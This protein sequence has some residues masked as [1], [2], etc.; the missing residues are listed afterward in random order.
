MS[1]VEKSAN[2]PNPFVRDLTKAGTNGCDISET[3][4]MASRVIYNPHSVTTTSIITIRPIS[5]GIF[6]PTT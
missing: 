5:P 6:T 4:N 3:V 1:P 2:T